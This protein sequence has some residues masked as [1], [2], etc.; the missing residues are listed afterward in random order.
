MLTVQQAPKGS[1]L[2]LRFNIAVHVLV[3]LIVLL[4][5]M[6]IGV[7]K[8]LFNV[9]VRNNV[10][11]LQMKKQI[12]AATK[13]SMLTQ[14]Q[15]VLNALTPIHVIN[16]YYDLIFVTDLSSISIH[17]NHLTVNLEMMKI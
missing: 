14:K 12:I 17:K 8:N 2:I 7:L 16:Q 1:A 11:M 9:M 13:V 6:T 15:N 4:V 10:Q 5:K 3:V